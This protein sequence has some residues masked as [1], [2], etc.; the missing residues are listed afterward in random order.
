MAGK[1]NY[2]FLTFQT[3]VLQT[4]THVHMLPILPRGGSTVGDSAF[5]EPWKKNA[6]KLKGEHSVYRVIKMPISQLGR[7]VALW[8]NELIGERGL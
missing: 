7:Q 8:V 5:C 4:N 6:A 2:C 3:E 1:A